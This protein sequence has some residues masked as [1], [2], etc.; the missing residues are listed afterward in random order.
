MEKLREQLRTEA[1]GVTRYAIASDSDPSVRTVAEQ[2]RLVAGEQGLETTVE[3]VDNP[4]SGET[5]VER[6]DV[7]TTRT[8]SELDW[9]PTWSIE[10]A[11]REQLSGN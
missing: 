11:I 6:F 7:D 8:Q 10:E 9:E 3:L 2:V 4:R 1:V 5:T